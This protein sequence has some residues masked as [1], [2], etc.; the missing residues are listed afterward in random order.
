MFLKYTLAFFVFCSVIFSTSASFAGNLSLYSFTEGAADQGMP[1]IT[2]GDENVAIGDEALK[3]NTSGSNNTAVG[4]EALK[5]NTTGA[6]NTAGAKKTGGNFSGPKQK[7]KRGYPMIVE[8]F[9]KNFS[10]EGGCPWTKEQTWRSIAR[11][12]LEEVYE[13]WDAILREDSTAI[14]GELADLCL[15]LVIY[16]QLAEQDGWFAWDDIVQAAIDK[17]RDRRAGFDWAKYSSEEAHQHW[18]SKKNWISS[19]K[20]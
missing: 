12:S 1:N 4:D 15:H 10:K 8:I 3:A 7:N 2:S 16:S 20:S 6:K 13:L 11:Y 9:E 19:L 5:A 14:K 17:Q 18:N